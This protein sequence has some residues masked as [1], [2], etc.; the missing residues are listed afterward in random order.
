[1]TR[2]EELGISAEEFVRSRWIPNEW[3]SIQ[4]PRHKTMYGTKTPPEMWERAATYTA[5]REEAIAMKR[6]DI[7]HVKKFCDAVGRYCHE[8]PYTDQTL[9]VEIPNLQSWKRILAVLEGQLAEMLK[10]W[11]EN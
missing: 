2:W 4:F 5:E 1:M 8:H 9:N 3:G 11:K 10:R 7:A 6:F